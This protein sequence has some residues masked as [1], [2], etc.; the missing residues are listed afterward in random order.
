MSHVSCQFTD[1]EQMCQGNKQLLQL[2]FLLPSHNLALSVSDLKPNKMCRDHD[3]NHIDRKH[4]FLTTTKV[5]VSVNFGSKFK[6]AKCK[7]L[8]LSYFVLYTPVLK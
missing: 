8:Y 1:P 6:F 7:M 4:F 5:S 2:L 3:D